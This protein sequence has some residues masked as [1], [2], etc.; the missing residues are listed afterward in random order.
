MEVA[1][2]DFGASFWDNENVLELHGS[3]DNTVM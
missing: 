2:S 1:V 3:D